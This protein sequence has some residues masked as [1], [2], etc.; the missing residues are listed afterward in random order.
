MNKNKKINEKPLS[1]AGVLW[2]DT[3]WFH[4][5]E[6]LKRYKSADECGIAIHGAVKKKIIGS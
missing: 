2:S 6:P 4:Y 5:D 1:I 3:G